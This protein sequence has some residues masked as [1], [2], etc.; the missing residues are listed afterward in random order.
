M[1]SVESSGL[2]ESV[3]LVTGA[4]YP[5]ISAAGLQAQATAATLADRVRFGV[6]TTAIDSSLPETEV[7]DGVPVFRIAVDVRSRRSKATASLRLIRR[8]LQIGRDYAI[9]HVHG[10]SRKNVPVTA[11]A[12]LTGKK[13]VLTLHTAGQDEPWAV[14]RSGAVAYRAFTAAD[15]VLAVSPGLRSAYADAVPGTRVRLAPNGIDLT[16]FRPAEPDEQA[17]LRRTLGL[18]PDLPIVLFVGFFSR[19]K[20]PDVLFRAWQRLWSDRQLDSAIVFVGATEPIYHEIDSALV[21]ELRAAASN[22]RRDRV[23]FAPPT[24]AIERYFRAA[25]IF[26]LPSAREAHPVALLEAMACGLPCVA[27]RLP[28]ATDVIIDSGAN[29]RLM[30]VDDELAL[31]DALAA[32]LT[33]AA[34]ARQMGAR[35]RATMESSFDIRRTSEAWMTAYRDV[36]A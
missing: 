11:I 22:G 14:R 7:V 9:V 26:A 4:Y 1:S 33:D 2:R 28:G 10:F 25:T 5:E 29:G 27:S 16:R 35:A 8:L 3:L 24:H 34:A 32:F 12:R 23:F 31:A 6:L 20:R 13:I 17:A 19:D 21:G 18:P 36:L 15:L 30:P